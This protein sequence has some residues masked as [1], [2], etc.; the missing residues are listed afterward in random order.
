[1]GLSSLLGSKSL[2]VK[3]ASPLWGF[4]NF[5]DDV[6]TIM[7]KFR[8]IRYLCIQSYDFAERIFSNTFLKIE[9]NIQGYKV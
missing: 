7:I 6:H 4:H 3:N 2:K 9:T 1:M 8:N 5:Q